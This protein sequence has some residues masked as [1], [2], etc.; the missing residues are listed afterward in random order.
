MARYRIE[1]QAGGEVVV[2]VPAADADG[3]P[4]TAESIAMDV[5]NATML[6]ED[7]LADD[8]ADAIAS[9][10][11]IDARE[12]TSEATIEHKLVRLDD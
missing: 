9:E 1:W 7:D 2:D 3:Q 8:L 10:L 12:M 6:I 4:H 11:D 5:A